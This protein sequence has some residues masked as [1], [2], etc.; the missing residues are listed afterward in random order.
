MTT[1]P[2]FTFK[3]TALNGKNVRISK[4]YVE[5]FEFHR[6]ENDKIENKSP[7]ANKRRSFWFRRRFWT[8]QRSFCTANMLIWFDITRPARGADRGL[9]W[10]VHDIW[11]TLSSLR[12]TSSL[13]KI[14]GRH[15][16]Q[17]GLTSVRAAENYDTV[18]NVKESTWLHDVIY[19]IR[20]FKI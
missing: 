14:R 11:L 2:L 19:K 16:Q 12:A 1:I 7:I 17:D 15:C 3:T 20:R 4:Y 13:E 6:R 10:D 18:R 8:E 5:I 9:N